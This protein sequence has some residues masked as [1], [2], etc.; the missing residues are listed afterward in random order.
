MNRVLMGVFVSLILL[1][2]VSATPT[3]APYVRPCAGADICTWTT[4]GNP[5]YG[6]PLGGGE[7]N[8][9][10][11]G[12]NHNTFWLVGSN[13]VPSDATA[14]CKFNNV[15][16]LNSAMLYLSIDNDIIEC[17]LNG[18][19]V[20][21]YTSHENC[22]P[23]NPMVGGYSTSLNIKEGENT[24]VCEVRDRGVMSHFDACVVPT[25]TPVV[26]EFGAVVGVLTVLGAVGVF[27]VIRR[28]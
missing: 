6:L 13:A 7:E 2:V 19:K 1:S 21:D 15:D 24:L 25:T 17:T 22:A 20:V 5:D 28:K 23:V 14:T 16:D 27:F 11:C 3:V 10:Q 26:P 18:V 8:A 4:S 12:L 9:P